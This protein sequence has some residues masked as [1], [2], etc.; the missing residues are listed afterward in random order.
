MK[1]TRL[2]RGGASSGW[3]PESATMWSLVGQ[4]PFLYEADRT[5]CSVEGN[6]W[7]VD[8]NTRRLP[9]RT[10]ALRVE[11]ARP[12]KSEECYPLRAKYAVPWPG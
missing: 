9:R 3:T 5:C 10:L 2:F 6:S 11:S 7:N 4:I 12:V 1:L 8:R